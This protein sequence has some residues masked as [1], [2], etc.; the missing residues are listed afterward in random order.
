MNE[1]TD[2]ETGFQYLRARYYDPA[3]GQFISRD[4]LVAVTRSA[5]GY[6]GGNP[7]NRIDP[8]GLNW[9][10]DK[11]T[12]GAGY[13]YDHRKGIAQGLAVAG[14]VVAG[15]AIAPVGAAA[16][17]A[18]LSSLSGGVGLYGT[19]AMFAAEVGGLTATAN[20][21]A[22]TSGVLSFG[23]TYLLCQDGLTTSCQISLASFGASAVLSGIGAVATP[24]Y[25]LL[26][27]VGSAIASLLGTT[28]PTN[29]S[30]VSASGASCPA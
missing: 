21:L 17:T 26:A 10:S 27:S 16:I 12:Q 13:V 20:T 14:V 29:A 24:L 8:A 6:T 2:A 30:A 3:T 1:Y 7:L 22:L 23:S 18:G 9:I 25:A 19:A 28:P 4:P 11:V 15:I 5:Y